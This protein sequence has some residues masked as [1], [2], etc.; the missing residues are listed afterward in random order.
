MAIAYFPMYGSY[1]EIFSTLSDAQIGALVRGSLHYFN[2][3]EREPMK[4][5][6]L[7]P[8]YTMLCRDIDLSGEA[9]E[10]GHPRVNDGRRIAATRLTLHANA[11]R[12]MRTHTN[13]CRRM[14]THANGCQIKTKTK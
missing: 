2:S 10:A 9:Y 3:G 5:P 13:G 14:R 7:I 11:C 8:L 6:A 1:E 12:R 4:K